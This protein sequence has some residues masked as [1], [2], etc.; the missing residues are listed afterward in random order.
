[1]D[2]QYKSGEFDEYQEHDPGKEFFMNF[3]ED[4]TKDDIGKI[5][6]EQTTNKE[7]AVKMVL[8]GV[9]SIIVVIL[10]FW[11]SFNLGKKLFTRMPPKQYLREYTYT[12]K[13]QTLSSNE[14]GIRKSNDKVVTAA[15]PAAKPVMNQ[16]SVTQK[17]PDKTGSVASI[18]KG[19]CIVAGSFSSK[20]SAQKVSDKLKTSGFTSG[21]FENVVK[22]KTV[23]RVIIG[24]GMTRPA[25]L[26]IQQK[27]K[28]IGYDT[29]LLNK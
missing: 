22:G 23:Y 28:K 14:I 11:G 8:I 4:D 24:Q 20:S 29:F 26:A 19:Y 18:A 6:E 12:A 15:K 13:K 25:A 7:S 3:P 1:M 17:R 9:I 27:A 10:S 16:P 5:L 21:V 2:D